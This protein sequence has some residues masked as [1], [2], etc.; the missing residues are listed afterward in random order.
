MKEKVDQV[1]VEKTD[2][3]CRSCKIDEW[4]KEQECVLFRIEAS[5][6]EL[7]VRMVVIE[8][9]VLYASEKMAEKIVEV[10]GEQGSLNDE[11]K[12]FDESVLKLEQSVSDVKKSLVFKEDKPS[13]LEG[14]EMAEKM[15]E[16]VI[17]SREQRYSVR[18]EGEGP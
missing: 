10:R 1:K 3:E 18:K 5:L 12:L 4:K 6:V 14:K 7:D 9:F 15:K 16:N 17:G 13:A 8:E 2:I 11:H